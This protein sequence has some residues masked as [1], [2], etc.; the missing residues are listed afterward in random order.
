MVQVTIICFSGDLQS[1]LSRD[2]ESDPASVPAFLALGVMPRFSLARD[3]P[4]RREE[5]ARWKQLLATPDLYC[6]CRIHKYGTVGFERLPI[7]S[8][9][10]GWFP[11]PNHAVDN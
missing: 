2:E 11:S 8:L 1:I 3:V 4:Q 7:Q 5:R 9:R 6:Q 10:G